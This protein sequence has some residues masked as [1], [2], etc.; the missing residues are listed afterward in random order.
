MLGPVNLNLFIY[1]D[2]QQQHNHLGSSDTWLQA[3]LSPILLICIL[4]GHR[5]KNLEVA[6]TGLKPSSVILFFG[7]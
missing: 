4:S 5:K 6:F 7:L 2:N 3:T 1:N